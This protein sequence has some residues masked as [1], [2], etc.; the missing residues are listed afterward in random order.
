MTRLFPRNE[1]TIDRVLRVGLG[2]GVLSLVFVGPETP[3]GWLGVVP[4]VT[5]LLG[6]CPAYTV[7][8]LSTCPMPTRPAAR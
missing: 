6:S 8:G 7:L 1:G 5:G 2:L 3:W 4:I